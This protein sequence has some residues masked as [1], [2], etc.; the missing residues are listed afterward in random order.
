VTNPSITFWTRLE[1]RARD[2]TMDQSL[3]AQVRDPLWF[4]ARQW[5]VGEFAGHDRGSPVQAALATKSI[6]LS[7]YRPALVE[8]GS[9]AL[10][11]GLPLE[12]HVERETVALGLRASVQL[13]LMFEHL[14]AAQSGLS[15]SDAQTLTGLFR[16]AYQISDTS[17]S[18]A[19]ELLAADFRLLAAGRVTD[20]AA[21]YAAAKPVAPNLPSEPT[22]DPSQTQLVTAATDAIAAFLGYC[23]SLYTQPTT[24]SSWVSQQLEHQFSLGATDGTTQFDLEADDFDG[25]D[26]DWFSFNLGS[27]PLASS[28][29]EVQSGQFAFVPNH[30]HFR[31][32]PPPSW[33]LM[34]DGRVDFGNLDTATTDL[35]K[36]LVMEFA[37]VYGNDWFELPLR[38][39]VGTLHSIEALVVT[40]TFGERTAIESTASL[41]RAG[42][43][44]W[45]MFSLTNA[46]ANTDLLLL[47]PTLVDVLE[48]D[49]LEQVLFMRDEMAAMGWGIEQIVEGAL[50]RGVS[51]YEAW[52]QSLAQS[53]APGPT[54]SDAAAISYL[55]GTS[56]PG[57]WLPLVPVQSSI[58]S[59][60]FR[61]GIMGTP[62]APPARGEILEPGQAL[63][64][65]D[66]AIPRAGTQVQRHVRRV[67]WTDGT[68]WT[69]TGR[70]RTVGR[71]EGSSGLAFDVITPN[72]AQQGN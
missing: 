3:Q 68:T 23:E 30:V 32:M 20:G 13:G 10:D 28:T 9:I 47:L 44:P 35:A 51:G 72:T 52:L 50:D 64:I 16:S 31:G 55:V 66:E 70:E 49:P 21:L 41:A 5:Q 6:A 27:E 37:L 59:F 56:V 12:A 71:G 46:D 61:R 33:W 60:L 2:A 58:R 63:Y 39:P 26:L 8:P 57:N 48:S 34:E 53:A 24:D 40:D 14:I 19:P 38:L 42:N 65:A 43:Q 29:A 25:G 69:W 7:A 15:Q 1:P 54:P 67:R 17:T 18:D 22:I 11:T 36:M 62:G 4:L 45:S